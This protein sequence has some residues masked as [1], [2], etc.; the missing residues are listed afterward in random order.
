MGP[1]VVIECVG[2]PGLIQHAIDVAAVDA[3]VAVCGVCMEMDSVLP[4]IPITKELDLRF[5]FYYRMRDYRTTIDLIHQERLDPSPL[6]TDE[7]DLDALPE[8][9]EALKHPTHECK[10]LV[11]P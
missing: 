1:R 5:T 9:F 4:L 6:I 10:V 11:R 3:T 8:R 2:I 7:C